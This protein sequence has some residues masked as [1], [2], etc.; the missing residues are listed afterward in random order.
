MPPSFRQQAHPIN[1]NIGIIKGGDWPSTVPAVAEFHARLAFFPGVEYDSVCKLIEEKIQRAAKN[2][3]W[4][5]ANPP[6]VSFYGFRSQ[7]HSLSRTLP[8]LHTLNACHKSLTG[9]DAASCVACCTTDLR[10]FVHYGQG[11]AT[12]Y[13]PVAEAIHAAN[14]R[15]LIESLVDTTKT[16]ALFLSRWCGLAE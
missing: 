5:A 11:Q 1:L 9:S 6:R 16:Y 13:G 8:A 4:L 15:V 7:G 12:C 2:D 14:E 10:A 3:P